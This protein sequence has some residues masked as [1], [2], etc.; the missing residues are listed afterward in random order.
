MSGVLRNIEF[1]N[2]FM[3]SWK[4]RVYCGKEV[5]SQ[6]TARLKE[7]GSEV[8]IQESNWHENGMFWRYMPIGEVG[9][10][11]IAFRD[12]DSRMSKRDIAAL[13]EWLESDFPVHIIRD[14][15]FHQTPILGGLWG[16]NNSKVQL[17]DFWELADMYSKSYGED[18]KFLANHVYPVVHKH[19]LI[20]DA[21]FSFECKNKSLV[22]FANTLEFM[23]ESY[24][25]DET[26]DEGLRNIIQDYRTNVWYRARLRLSS[27]MQSK[28]LL[29]KSYFVSQRA[30]TIPER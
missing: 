2:C 12:A 21:Y 16:I 14:H 28:F 11:H 8:Y 27:F 3:S 26:I 10:E 7:L 18:Q 4:T 19:A 25:D 5:P 29:C 1:L 24:E 23:G 6:V 15:P 13:N 22:N 20:F 9:L 30:V 17:K